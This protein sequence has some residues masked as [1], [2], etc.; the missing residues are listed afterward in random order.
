[1]SDLADKFK[2]EKYVYIHGIISPEESHELTKHMFALHEE[3]KT[4]K[5]DLCPLSESIYN[6]EKFNIV[7]RKLCAP[8]SEILGIPLSPSYSYARLYK[9]GESLAPHLDREACEISGTITLGFDP[10]QKV[11]PISFGYAQDDGQLSG[12]SIDIE[13][14]DAVMY[15]GTELGHWRTLFK[16]TWQV[17]LFLHY[18]NAE[19]NFGP[20]MSDGL[21]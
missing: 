13:V 15:R 10:S 19:K 18:L 17:Q 8:L 2:K 9:T 20:R 12:H 14:G 3:K 1:M 5:D 7:L 16:G 4:V 6:D 21:I 11:W